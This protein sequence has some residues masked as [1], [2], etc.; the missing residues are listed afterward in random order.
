MEQKQ[1]VLNKVAEMFMRYGIKSV[2]MDD[3]SSNLGI[4]K[5]TLYQY[6][7][8]KADLIQQVFQQ[9]IED[10]T[11]AMEM[12]VKESKDAIEEILNIA[13]YITNLL[14][15]MSPNTLYDLR[16]YYREIWD[17]MQGLHQK[18]IHGVI[19]NNIER[20][21]NE[22]LYRAD[23]DADIISKLYVSCNTIIVDE[24]F[25]PLKQYN[26]ERLFLEH[27][28]Y[29]IFGIASKKGLRLLDKYTKN[30]K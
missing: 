29:H 6:V 20:G 17:L 14:R 8:N 3:I 5:K 1:R 19:Y 25:F 26:T 23:I 7:D 30:K 28:K 27:I 18:Q 22:A 24:N 9:H 15:M 2:T 11:M 16:K 21:V 13:K 12:L 4:S 10:E